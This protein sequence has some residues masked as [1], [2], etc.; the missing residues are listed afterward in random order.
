MTAPNQKIREDRSRDAVCYFFPLRFSSRHS[1]YSL[2]RS[3][4]FLVGG[5]KFLDFWILESDRFQTRIY[6]N[7]YIILYLET[8]VAR[9]VI[10]HRI[11]QHFDPLAG[12]V[13]IITIISDEVSIN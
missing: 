10:F 5:I 9:H 6:N 12:V 8:I 1:L 11:K 13:D 4:V 3:L 2:L 7:K